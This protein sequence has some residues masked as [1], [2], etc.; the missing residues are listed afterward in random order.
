MPVPHCNFGAFLRGRPLN[1]PQDLSRLYMLH[2]HGS[3]H[4]LW[5]SFQKDFM[6]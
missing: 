6:L 2:G 1:T 4:K 3:V 5:D